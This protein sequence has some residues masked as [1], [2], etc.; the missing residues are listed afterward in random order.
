MRYSEQEVSSE[1][2]DQPEFRGEPRKI[3]ICS[4]P[5]SGSYMLCRYMINAGLGVPHEYF[6]PINMRQIALRFGLGG[7]VQALRWRRRSPWDNLPFSSAAR[8]RTAEV[9]FL[10]KYAAALVLRRCQHG[11]FAAK[12][13][14]DQYLKVLDNPVGRTLL[15]GGLFVH[16]TRDDLLAQAVSTHFSNLTGRWSIDDN[17]ATAPEAQPNFFDLQRIDR[18]MEEL[19][20]QNR[21][22]RL[23]LARN[24]VAQITLSYER[25]CEDPFAVVIELARR[26]GLNPAMLRRGYSEA[27]AHAEG[28]GDPN[29]PRKSEVI[30]RYLAAFRQIRGFESAAV[31]AVPPEPAKA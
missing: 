2:L 13:H 3:Y 14:F 23:F 26:L 27:G 16:L 28:E 6:N 21:G 30:R 4:T 10:R 22:W 19:A 9:A 18:T 8:A 29:V 5:R 7:E 24:G 17:L 12:V 31:T 25:L 15:D 20:E 11:V 1:L